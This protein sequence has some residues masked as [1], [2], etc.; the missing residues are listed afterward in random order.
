MVML[1]REPHFFK[2]EELRSA[3]E[4]AWNV[5][6]AG[7]EDSKHTVVQSGHVTLMKAGP[8]LLNLLQSAKPYIENPQN[9]VE[10]LPQVIQRE[11]WAKHR[12]CNAVDY[13]NYEADV[14]LAYSVLAGFVG[15]LIDGNC[16][17]IYIPGESS[18]I[19]NDASLYFQLKQM[20]ST[21]T[22]GSER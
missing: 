20:A 7:G 13:L 21:R 10:W 16:T 9:N 18:L 8:H 12:A 17:G 22:A 2:A 14:E 1:L 19:P 11:A 4:R 3:A 6:F 15:E 5:S